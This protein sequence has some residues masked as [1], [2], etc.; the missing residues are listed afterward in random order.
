MSS[1]QAYQDYLTRTKKTEALI[2]K[3]MD[4]YNAFQATVKDVATITQED[5]Y[6]FI[7]PDEA[8]C[9]AGQIKNANEFFVHFATFIEKEYP[10]LADTAAVI[11]CYFHSRF[12][13]M[14]KK[15][16]ANLRGTILPM[17]NN[18]KIDPRHLT[19]MSNDDFLKAFAQWRQIVVSCYDKIEAAPFLWGY[20]DYVTTDGAYSRLMD[21][22]FAVVFCGKYHQGVIT[23]DTKKIFDSQLV[24]CHRKP[25]RMIAGLTEVGFVFENYSKK[26]D[27]F[28]VSFPANPYVIAVMYA[29]ISQITPNKQSWQYAM[30]LK[31]LS[32]RF[33]EDPNL[34]AYEAVFLAELDY[35]TEELQEM[36]RWLYGEAA[37]YDFCVDMQ[38][39]EKGGVV[40]LTKGSKKFL[41]LK[42]GHREAGTN[43]FESHKTKIGT[44]VSFIHTFEKEPEKMRRLCNRF[45]HVFRLEDSG[46]CCNDRNP[47]KTPH[48]FADKS[49]KSGKRCAFVM[50]F[51]FSGVAY[52]RCGLAN[53]FFEDIT[54]DDAK[55]ILEMFLVENKIK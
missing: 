20:P 28:D 14:A 29:Y 11:R 17:P 1:K 12:E 13:S 24:K 43:H 27:S 55:M 26:S 25:D 6:H 23:V 52:K 30:T 21:I 22:L 40:H 32:Y 3:K 47:E 54:L 51:T 37:K 15:H 39:W 4:C 44:K 10:L 2:N 36:K 41:T 48:Q 35:D 8:N 31:S 49:E 19:E 33:V 53:F 16:V 9:R 46:T 5:I 45:P 34:Q 18:V 7:R 38:S 50:K 42:Q